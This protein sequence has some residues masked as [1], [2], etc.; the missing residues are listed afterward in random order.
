MQFILKYKDVEKEDLLDTVISE[1]VETN[2]KEDDSED[3]SGSSEDDKDLKEDKGE[4][5]EKEN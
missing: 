4:E 1:M 5:K 3:K 2:E